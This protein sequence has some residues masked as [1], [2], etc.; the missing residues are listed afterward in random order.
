MQRSRTCREHGEHGSLPGCIGVTVITPQ[1][2]AVTVEAGGLFAVVCQGGRKEVEEPQVTTRLFFPPQT[3]IAS[4]QCLCIP[5]LFL[6]E[7]EA[8]EGL[9]LG[10]LNS[11]C[12]FVGYS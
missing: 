9:F 3:G 7:S 10:H 8:L 2:G 6:T 4:L 12:F 1:R 11:D 5:P